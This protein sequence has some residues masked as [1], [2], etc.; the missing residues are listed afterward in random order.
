MAT[1]RWS[2]FVVQLLRE[3]KRKKKQDSNLPKPHT[4]DAIPLQSSV[5]FTKPIN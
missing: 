1:L 5:T 2:E 3:R 4:K